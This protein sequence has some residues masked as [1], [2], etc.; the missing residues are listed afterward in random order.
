MK[1]AAV[2]FSPQGLK[3]CQRLRDRIPELDI[4]L[5]D[6]LQPQAGEIPFT[7]VLE[8]TPQL[9]PKYQ[10]LIY[11]A[12]CGV[13]VRSLV[14]CPRSKYSDP[15]VLVVDVGA[16]HVVSLL[17]GHEGGANDLA[18]RVA[19]ILDADPVIT[20]TTEA[21]K[22]LIVG[23]GC[24]KGKPAAEIV[25]AIKKVCSEQQLDLTRVRFLATAE[26]KAEEAGLLEAARE[27]AIPLRIVGHD[28]IRNCAQEFTPSQFVTDKVALP[29]V[30]EPAALVAGRRTTLVV[31]RQA[32]DGITIAV[33]QE[34]C[35]SLA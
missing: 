8:L 14:D 7:R 4:Y 30:A 33:A 29:A 16:R 21:V 9:F 20:T 32:L 2:T 12:P 31:K 22:D 3:V 11:V 28:S 17:S 24:R 25:A 19:N 15:A 26:V 1:L 5:H 23:V 6:A 34:N 35:S 18:I 10:G 13:V 27:L